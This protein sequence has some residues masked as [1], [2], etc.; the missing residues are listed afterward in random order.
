MRIGTVLHK[1]RINAGF[2]VREIGN[3]IGVSAST[4]SR[5]ENGE[6][7]S[8]SAMLAVIVWLFGKDENA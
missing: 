4:I 3:Q 2:T 8:A 1:W 6:D 5:I 7:I